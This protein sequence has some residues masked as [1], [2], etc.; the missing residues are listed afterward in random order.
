VFLECG[1]I[2]EKY[3]KMVRYDSFEGDEDKNI[4][5]KVILI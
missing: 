1:I 2:F 5:N 3:F 4:F